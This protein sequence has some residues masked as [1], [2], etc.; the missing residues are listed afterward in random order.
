[1]QSRR[2]FGELEA[3]RHSVLRE[4][5]VLRRMWPDRPYDLFLAVDAM[6]G[7]QA[8]VLRVPA[9]D[10]RVS[11]AGLSTKAIAVDR[12]RLP[13]DKPAQESI[14]VRLIDARFTDQ[15]CKV[16]DDMVSGV[17]GLD[18]PVLVWRVLGARLRSWQRLFGAED[19]MS[20]SRQLGLYGELLV[21]N[22]IA[23][24]KTWN[25]AIESWTGPAAADR[26]FRSPQWAVEVKTRHSQGRNVVHISNEHQLDTAPGTSLYLWVVTVT[27]H[28]LGASTLPALV[29]NVREK[30]GEQ[31]ALLVRFEELI[32]LAGYS[33][34][35]FDGRQVP[36]YTVDDHA[37]FAIDGTSPRIVPEDLKRGVS[38]VRYLVDIGVLSESKVEPSRLLDN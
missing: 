29:R 10:G 14:V 35:L 21:L 36:S 23:L 34:A 18:D 37:L 25:N 33:D 38:G 22:E 11:I 30:L 15:F 7:E 2:I 16:I 12:A 20:E 31:P 3:A 28:E 26:D 4:G 24:L 8:V 17:S 13:D 1:M 5:L 19:G 9:G 6:S 32:E 27:A